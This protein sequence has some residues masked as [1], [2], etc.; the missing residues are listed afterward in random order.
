MAGT[1][2]A[3]QK[4]FAEAVALLKQD[5]LYK[6]AIETAAQSKDEA[7]VLALL[8]FFVKEKEKECFAAM[9]Y[10]C[11]DLLSPDVVLELAWRNGLSDQAMAFMVQ[12]SKD[13]HSKLKELDERTK[14][15]V[16]EP[17]PGQGGFMTDGAGNAYLLANEPAYGGVGGGY[18]PGMV[19]PPPPQQ[20]Y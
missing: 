3:T 8:T 13:V 14:P 4:K 20:Y 12:W 1:L 2:Y 15:K 7:L 19:M 9:L 18:A 10:A 6:E 16:E 11:Y 5:R 17:K